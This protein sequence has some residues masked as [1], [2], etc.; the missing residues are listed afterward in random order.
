MP[1]YRVFGPPGTGKTTYLARQVANAASRHGSE[2]V[3]VS[4]FTRAA[5]SEV[6]S[7]N[8]PIPRSQV[9]TLHAHCYRLLDRPEIAESHAEEWNDYIRDHYPALVLSSGADSSALDEPAVERGGSTEGDALLEEVGRLRARMV[10]RDEWP[11]REA[12]MASLWEDWKSGN[13]LLDFD[14]LIEHA[15]DQGIGPPGAP[16]VGFFDEAQDFTPMELTLVRRWSEEMEYVVLVG[17]DDQCIYHFTGA[18]ARAF[19]EPEVPDDHKRLLSQSFRVPRRVHE[20]AERWIGELDGLDV[21]EPKVYEPRED[22]PGEVDVLPGTT[23]RSPDALRAELDLAL[24]RG[25]TA[26]ILTTCSYMLEPI[27]RLLR[28]AAIPFANPYRRKRGDW[29]PLAPRR[30]STTATDRVLAYTRPD[31]RVWGEESR[32]WSGPELRAWLEACKAEGLIARGQKKRLREIAEAHPH[33]VPLEVLQGV[34]VDPEAWG[35]ALSMDL[36]WLRSRLSAKHQRPMEFPMRVLRKH[37]LDALRREPRVIIGTIHSVKGGE[38]DE[39]FLFPDLSG[40]AVAE[41]HTDEG[42]AAIIRQ[43]YVGITR[44]RRRLVL[45]DPVKEGAA[46]PVIEKV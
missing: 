33:E 43:F 5:A 35:R 13:G 39:V 23:W 18:T 9:G 7:R 27:K 1:E 19:L 38:A 20:V 30:G 8:V 21:R 25:S 29:N 36:G 24:S 22:D 34:F 46:A 10:P 28:D 6:A 31:E 40:S 32:M 41:W 37:G 4:S 15:L 16:R 14:D 44:A 12:A 2:R 3:I 26:M 11:Q 42:R 17:D 45:C